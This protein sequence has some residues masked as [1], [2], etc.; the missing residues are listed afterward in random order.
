PGAG[1]PFVFTGVRVHATGATA[2]RVRVRGEAGVGFEVV[3]V[4]ESGRPVVS[5]DRVVLRPLTVDSSARRDLYEV[6]WQPREVT[7]VALAAD[8]T[9]WHVPPLGEGTVPHAVDGLVG[10]ALS[11]VGRW[12]SSVDGG[13]GRWGW[14]FGG[15]D[16]GAGAVL[17]LLR[18]AAAEHPGRIVLVEGDASS[19][20]L[21]GVV[22]AGL[23][24]V[25]VRDGVV[26]VPGLV[27]A[28][29]GG[30]E[31]GLS[32][33]TVL[34]TGGFGAL[35]RLVARWLVEVCGAGEVVLVGRGGGV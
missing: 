17:G 14:L 10:E 22:A 1:L 16:L 8:V 12:L 31:F 15:N 33:G 23:Q 27:R 19:E 32:G 28:V 2:L 34:V 29:P 24:E 21:G 20:V 4:D 18:V 26:L 13:P 11:V 6:G 3:A 25:T 30:A 7:P 5:I 35:G 9:V